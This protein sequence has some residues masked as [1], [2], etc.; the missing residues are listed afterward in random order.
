MSRRHGGLRLKRTRP[1]Y[2]RKCGK[3]MMEPGLA[4]KMV[5]E[6]SC[7][8]GT[9]GRRKKRKMKI[10]IHSTSKIVELNGVPARIWEGQTESG[11]KLHC[12]VTRIA[13]DKKET[14]VQEFEHDLQEHRAPSREIEA[15]PLR[16]IL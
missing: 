15:I 10:T 4:L 14:R 8:R 1:M 12:Y 11:I 6:A 2:C 3:K 13:I 7:N 5:H 16:M 9:D